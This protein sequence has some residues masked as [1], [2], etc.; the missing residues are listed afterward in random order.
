MYKSANDN[1]LDEL[2]R[3]LDE[4]NAGGQSESTDKETADLLAVAALIKKT[5]LPPPAP[6]QHILDETVDLI[7]NQVPAN[8]RKRPINWLYSGALGTAASIL[9]VIGLNTM[10]W[11]PKE[12]PPTPIAEKVAEDQTLSQNTIVPSQSPITTQHIRLAGIPSETNTNTNTN[13]SS[14]PSAVQPDPSKSQSPAETRAASTPVLQNQPSEVPAKSIEKQSSVPAPKVSVP[15]PNIIPFSL[16]GRVPDI[17]I[18]DSK[19]GT[20]RQVYDKGTSQEIIITQSTQP[21]QFKSSSF[22][23][24]SSAIA[25]E[26]QEKS[27]VLDAAASKPLN[28]VTMIINNEEV[29]VEGYLSAEELLKLGESLSQTK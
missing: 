20:L 1:N 13:T 3:L 6:P 12:V 14:S 16:P 15:A 22:L 23:R 27:A 19:D 4:L 5:N 7:L 28:K 26:R 10:P 8:S 29:T 9:L 21:E 18:S 2:S 25:E 17:V 24:K 11:W